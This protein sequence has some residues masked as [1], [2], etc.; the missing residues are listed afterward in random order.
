MF[1]SI[2]RLVLSLL[3]CA[4]LACCAIAHAAVTQ[5]LE[6]VRDRPDT[7]PGFA[8]TRPAN[9]S[10]G[11]QRLPVIVWANG[12][13]L[14]IDI[15]YRSMF[16]RWASQGFVII[17]V[18][19]PTARTGADPNNPSTVADQRA[20]IDWAAR[21]DR[22]SQS[23]YANRLDLSR[24]VAAGNSCGGRT[25]LELAAADTRVKSVYILSGASVNPNAPRAGAEAVISRV[26]VPVI[27]IVGGPEDI[28][29]A[30]ANLDFDLLR[31]GVAGMIVQRAS[32]D[33][34]TI[35]ANEAIHA[36]TAEI[37]L[38]WFK[39]TLYRDR[40][41]ARTLAASICDQCDPTIWTARHKNF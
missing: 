41:A 32:G 35:S 16:A 40:G 29:R 20:A 5:P 23:A 19:E 11:G 39:A 17:S 15:A 21:E 13:C 28:M 14:R 30:P 2:P 27:F 33:H 8:V 7:M 22:S 25:A 10:V 36:D 9:L 34:V 37:G 18:D 24:I 1:G 12:G 26:R 38:N 6:V 31:S 3:A 4:M